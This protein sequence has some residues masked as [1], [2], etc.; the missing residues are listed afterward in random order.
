MS[1]RLGKRSFDLTE[2][3]YYGRIFFDVNNVENAFD[4]DGRSYLFEPKYTDEQGE[5]ER[6]R[7]NAGERQQ[8]AP[9]L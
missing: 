7:H 5:S 1:G 4:F 6:G 2:R 8:T 3:N 9:W